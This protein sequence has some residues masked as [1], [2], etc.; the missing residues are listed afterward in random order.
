[1]KSIE[2]VGSGL[3]TVDAEAKLHLV[4]ERSKLYKSLKM[5]RP[6][7]HDQRAT[8]RDLPEAHV[9]VPAAKP[10]AKE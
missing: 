1:M 5:W 7:P 2:K 8:A 10:E 4:P 3:L 6:R 9:D